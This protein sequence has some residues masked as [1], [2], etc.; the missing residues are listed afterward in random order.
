[1]IFE[2]NDNSIFEA[3]MPFAYYEGYK[4]N[5]IACLFNGHDNGGVVGD[6]NRATVYLPESECRRWLAESDRLF[7]KIN[8]TCKEGA[9]IK[10]R[11]LKFVSKE[12]TELILEADAWEFV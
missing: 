12:H 3:S 6:D 4:F 7:P 9:R 11:N 5:V 10:F 8:G 2:T 1:M